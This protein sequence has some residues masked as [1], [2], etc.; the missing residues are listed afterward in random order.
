MGTTKDNSKK[1][2]EAEEIK[3]KWQE[4]TEEFCKK[5]PNDLENHNIVVTHLEL[6][7]PECEV[8]YRK[9]YYKQS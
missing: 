9:Q 3:K 7:I 1:L 8:N 5:G 6:D 2:T 4:Y